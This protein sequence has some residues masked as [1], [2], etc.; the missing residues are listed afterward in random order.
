VRTEQSASALNLAKAGLGI[1]LVPGNVIPVNF[2][3]SLAE[4]RPAVLR[5]LCVY[6]R[7]R[8]DPITAAFINAIA[9]E[10]LASPGL[11]TRPV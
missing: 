4:P 10:A 6:T 3:G 1:T 9:D 7:T 2:E 5:P 8:P 11:L